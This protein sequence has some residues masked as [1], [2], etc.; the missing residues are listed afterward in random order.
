LNVRHAESRLVPAEV[1]QVDDVPYLIT[2]WS[3]ATH[4]YKR[5]EVEDLVHV[6]RVAKFRQADFAAMFARVGLSI[7]AVYG[8]YALRPF[9]AESSPR[10]ILM[11][12]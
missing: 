2:R 4:F 10:L 7:E 8:D 12:R 5:I 11:A 9:D 3:D 1:K 6:E